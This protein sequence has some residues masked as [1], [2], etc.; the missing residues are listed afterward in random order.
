MFNFFARVAQGIILDCT[1]MV[2]LA[3]ICRLRPRLVGPC[4]P[5]AM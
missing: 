2:G 5:A 4:F 3:A 1:G